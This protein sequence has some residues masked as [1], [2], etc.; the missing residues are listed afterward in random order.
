MNFDHFYFFHERHTFKK[1]IPW[2]TSPDENS[3]LIL[4][5]CRCSRWLTRAWT[6]DSPLRT[7]YSFICPTICRPILKT[8]R[9][10]CSS[11]EVKKKTL[12]FRLPNFERHIS[13]VTTWLGGGY[14]SIPLLNL[15][16]PQHIS[17]S[18]SFSLTPT[19]TIVVHPNHPGDFTSDVLPETGFPVI[20]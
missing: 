15:V 20:H 5:F 2:I 1:N 18:K 17:L 13:S 6:D 10:G 19:T 11:R 3:N 14:L 16:R 8:R 7:L 9:S 12:I 4:W